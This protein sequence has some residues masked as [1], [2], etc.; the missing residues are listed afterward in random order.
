[1]NPLDIQAQ[2]IKEALWGAVSAQYPGLDQLTFDQA[3]AIIEG[4]GILPKMEA[5]KRESEFGGKS[6]KELEAMIGDDLILNNRLALEIIKHKGFNR[7][8]VN[9]AYNGLGVEVNMGAEGT[10]GKG[11][12]LKRKLNLQQFY[13]HPMAS[14]IIK[15]ILRI[16]P[17]AR[18]I[19]PTA[20]S[21]RLFWHMPNQ[22]MV[23][24]IEIESNAYDIAKALYPEAQIIQDDTSL[25]CHDGEFDYV[26]GNPPFTIYFDDVNRIFKFVGYNNKIISE[27]AIMEIAKRSINRGGIAMVMPTNAWENKFIDSESFVQ[28]FSEG[29]TPVAKIDFPVHTHEGTTWPVSLYVFLRMGW[30]S[31]RFENNTPEYPFHYKLKSFDKAEIDGMIKKFREQ[32]RELNNEIGKISDSVKSRGPYKLVNATVAKFDLGEYLKSSVEIQSADS[33]VLDAKLLKLDSFNIP[34]VTIIPN[35]IHADLKTRAIRSRYGLKY[36]PARKMHIDVFAESVA[37]LDFFMDPRHTYDNIPLIHN[38]HAYDVSITHSP[39]FQ[40]SLEMR[41]EWIDFQNVPLEIWV[42]S[43]VTETDANWKQMFENDGYKSKYPLEYAK[44]KEKM[45]SLIPEYPWIAKLFNFQKDD[46]IKMAMKA[47]VINALCM[48]LGKSRSAIAAALL[49]G[50]ERNLILC[51]KRLVNVWNEEFS[52][53]GLPLPF[54]VES[55]EDLKKME[56]HKWVITTLTAIRGDKSRPRSKARANP[57]HLGNDSNYDIPD[58]GEF[59]GDMMDMMEKMGMP[60]EMAS[61]VMSSKPISM[62]NPSRQ[63][64]ELTKEQQ[65]FQ[66]LQK[67]SLFVDNL[68]GKF[69]LLIVDEAHYL[70][71]PTTLQTQA[72]MRIQ[73]KHNI[74]LSGTPI[75]NRVKG[76][77]SLL[78]MGWGEE[79][80]ANPY[81]KAT[82]LEEFTQYKE[83]TNEVADAHGYISTKK[84]EIEIPQIKNPEKLQSLMA[85]KWIRRTKYEPDVAAD[86]KFPKPTINFIKINPSK[87]ER[88]YS[89]QWYSEYKRLKLLIQENKDELKALKDADPSNP[90]VAARMKELKSLMGI[91]IT[92]IMKLRAVA[93]APQI[94]WLKEK[95]VVQEK[96]GEDIEEEDDETVKEYESSEFH[97]N[98]PIPFPKGV[99]TPRQIHILNE[100]ERRVKMGEQCYTIVP[101]PAVNTLLREE[102]RKRGIQAEVIDG[103]VGMEHRNMIITRFREKKVNLILATIGTFDVGI[104]I[105]D[106]EYCCIIAPSWTWSS[107]SQ[108][109]ERMIRPSSQGERTVDILYLDNSIESYVKQLVD[110]KRYNQ[111]YV[112]DY[113]P[114]PPETPWQGW[115]ECVDAMFTD[116]MKGEF[117]V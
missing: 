10:Y 75:S 52:G 112:I 14:Y 3:W 16:P 67:R 80:A 4:M 103:S 99:L 21:G 110:M 11:I 36:S 64:L 60:E 95:M 70:S 2:Q 76:L 94:N 111:N 33:V 40:K 117:N 32:E 54:L 86:R 22:K 31:R 43:E 5:V 101:F 106:A 41:K 53:L 8:I 48:G 81:N 25:H 114:R 78:I 87:E 39:D 115:T 89:R 83:I 79:T 107:M 20:G 65:K 35:G 27:M 56:D 74:F 59:E 69:D 50:F 85:P 98:I 34:P 29:M 46:V 47:S 90:E 19:D 45:E 30:S 13:T 116:L 82:F 73:P 51:P 57:D 84:K 88:E 92:M 6:L 18:V 7:N 49:K 66:E 105:P 15:E 12:V 37:K 91:S 28:W 93:C 72:A 58:L 62:E 23:H 63:E 109:M 97:I 77:L 61:A 108:A 102:L 96:M 104:N 113:G 68:R 1:M 44:W 9:D 24:G 17:N 100:L 26:I 38:L 42:A 55:N 71:N